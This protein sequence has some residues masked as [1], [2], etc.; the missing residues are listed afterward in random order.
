MQ[1]G[2]GGGKW[3]RGDTL[4]LLIKHVG[5]LG[6]GPHP[7][8]SSLQGSEIC[9]FFCFGELNGTCGH[10]H[11]FMLVFSVHTHKHPQCLAWQSPKVYLYSCISFCSTMVVFLCIS[12]RYILVLS[13]W[14]ETYSPKKIKRREMGRI[15]ESNMKSWVPEASIQIFFFNSPFLRKSEW[16]SVGYQIPLAWKGWLFGRGV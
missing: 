1:G 11:M 5:V 16:I 2:S 14:N 13:S 4:L 10:M 9:F 8:Y 7:G 3:C 15:N 12:N 6:L